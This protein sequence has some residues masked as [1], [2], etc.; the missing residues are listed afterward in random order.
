MYYCN[1]QNKP[2]E[3]SN[4]NGYCSIT[5]CKYLKLTETYEWNHVHTKSIKGTLTTGTGI[6]K[7]EETLIFPHTIGSITFHTKKELIDWVLMQQDEDYGRGNN[8]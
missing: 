5:A 2:C 1:T 7:N 4:I 8:A 6:M 3:L